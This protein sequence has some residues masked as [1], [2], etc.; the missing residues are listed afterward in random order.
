MRLTDNPDLELPLV[1][2][3]LLGEGLAALQFLRQHLP[4]VRFGAI[5]FALKPQYPR[6]RIVQFGELR[7]RSRREYGLSVFLVVGYRKKPSLEVEVFLCDVL[8]K[9]LR[10]SHLHLRIGKV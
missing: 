4:C 6:F 5:E 9:L 7:Y 1:L 8:S 10:L 2:R 3:A